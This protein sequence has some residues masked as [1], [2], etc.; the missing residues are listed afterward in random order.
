MLDFIIVDSPYS[1]LLHLTIMSYDIVFLS[2]VN[3]KT[4]VYCF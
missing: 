3:E 1:N 4:I 2:I